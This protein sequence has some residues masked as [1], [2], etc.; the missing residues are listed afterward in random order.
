MGAGSMTPAPASGSFLASIATHYSKLSVS[1]SP[2]WKSGAPPDWAADYGADEFGPFATFAVTDANGFL[3]TQVMRWIVPGQ[4]LMGS[5]EDE[6]GRWDD[7][8]PQHEVRLSQGFWIFDT[9]VTQ[10][11]WTAVMGDN[12]S[13]FKDSKRPIETVSWDDATQFL[14]KL[15]E[16]VPGLDLVLPTE[17]QW[18]YACRAGMGTATYA[19]PIEILGAHNAPVLDEIAWYGGNS[20]VEFELDNGYDSSGWSEKQYEHNRAGTHPVGLKLPNAWG[21]YDMLG[22]VDEWCADDMRKFGDEAVTD[23]A[24]ALDGAKRALRGGSWIDDARYVRAACRSVIFPSSRFGVVG[25]RC[26]R[27]RAGAEP[28][29]PG[30]GRAERETAPGR[31]GGAAVLALDGS[32]GK[33]SVELPKGRAFVVR[34]DCEILTFAPLTRP[35]WA[36]AMG[37]DR[38]GLWAEFTLAEVTQRMRWIGPGRFRMGSLEDELGRFSSE[39]PQ[40]EVRLSKGYWLFD[41]PVTQALWTE[42]MG[43]NPSN[44]KDKPT[45]PV[46][47]VTW[48]DVTRFL[49]RINAQV[50]VLDLVLPTEAQWEYACR[51]GTETP[52]YAGGERDLEDIAWFSKNSDRQTHPVAMKRCNAWGLHDMLGNVWEWCADDLRKYGGEAVTDPVGSLDGAG[53]A[54][55]GGSWSDDARYVRAAR[56]VAIAREIA[57]NSTGFRCARVWP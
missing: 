21:L 55:R 32:V 39:S 3:V 41:T 44:F 10:A 28:A 9:P 18:E 38:Y 50:P 29:E 52:N 1:T 57:L 7:E 24:G 31:R 56:R 14:E 8:G 35:G 40:H 19:G 34:S 48:N 27:V 2:F 37:R 12:P 4:F 42:V 33:T 5:P 17:A 43:D 53:R 23:P 20:G 51:A 47:E 46:E 22:N 16:L 6:P 49:E 25:F 26:A 11:L 13:R 15:N 30:P 54:L 45:Y 36:S